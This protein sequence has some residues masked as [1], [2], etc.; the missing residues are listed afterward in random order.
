MAVLLRQLREEAFMSGRKYSQVEL[1]NSVSEAIRC[2]LAA[3]EAQ[4]RAE[5]WAAALDEAA[6]T[7]ASFGPLAASAR[8]TLSRLRS[9]LKTMAGSFTES[10]LMSLSL[11]QVQAQRRQV[12]RLRAQLEE[13]ERRCREGNDDASLRAQLAAVLELARRNRDELEPWLRDVYDDFT[14]ETRA[15]LEQADLSV[16]ATGT[17]GVAAVRVGEQAARYEEMLRQASRRRQLDAERRYVAAAL[18][19]VCSEMAFGPRRPPQGGPLEDILLEVD[20]YAYG[21]IQFRLQLDGTIRSESELVETSCCANFALIEDKLRTLGVHSGF[22]YE[23][24]QQPV[25]LRKGEKS[26]PGTEPGAA[27]QGAL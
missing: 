9:Q 2:R 12:E 4:V 7:T 18:E 17:L 1:A 3:E 11:E 19:Q 27:T 6:Q 16:S 21:I 26:L 15:L 20:T 8:E 25:R 23:A 14:E 24:D 5:S 10:E 22:R 13:V